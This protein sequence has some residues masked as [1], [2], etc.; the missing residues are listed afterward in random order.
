MFF[1]QVNLAIEGLNSEEPVGVMAPGG[2]SLGL[3]HIS[4]SL[5]LIGSRNCTPALQAF[6]SAENA[7][8]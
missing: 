3:R 1:V 7:N 5:N 6:F 2:K 8:I 4:L